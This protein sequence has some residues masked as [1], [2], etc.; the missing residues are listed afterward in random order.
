MQ[1]GRGRKWR[2][3][4]E[5]ARTNNDGYCVYNVQHLIVTILN[6]SW[7]FGLEF[8]GQ[9]DTWN[10]SSSNY[11]PFF[12][13]WPLL[14]IR[15]P[16]WKRLPRPV[17]NENTISNPWISS[18]RAI[19][20]H[21]V[22]ENSYSFNYYIYLFYLFAKDRRIFGAK[23]QSIFLIK[24]NSIVFY[25]NNKCNNSP[26]NPSSF[27]DVDAASQIFFFKQAFPSTLRLEAIVN[28]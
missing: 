14:N 15:S 19:E 27:N 11:F 5:C 7:I 17:W 26:T 22:P 4:G 12:R 23:F 1:L 21:P 2:R 16:S 24:K 6:K 18:R 25:V 3:W 28:N 8:L 10:K 13:T 20:R 9:E